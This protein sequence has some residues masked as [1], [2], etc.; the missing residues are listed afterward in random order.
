M[1]YYFMEDSEKTAKK[2]NRASKMY[3]L[4]ESP[5]EKLA[6]SKYRKKSGETRSR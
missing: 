6:F 1:E 2:Y 3:D 4:M 5:I